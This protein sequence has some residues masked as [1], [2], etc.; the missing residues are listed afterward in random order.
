M[1]TIMTHTVVAVC[2][3]YT[4]GRTTLPK[5]FWVLGI[6]AAVLP[7][8]DVIGLKY[9]H[10]PYGHFLGHRG[11]FHS[12]CFAALFSVVAV[13]LFFRQEPI[14]SRRWVAYV[15]FFFAVG[16][17][18]GLL[19]AMTDGGRGVALLVPFIDERYFLPWTPIEVSPIGIRKF[20]SQRGL[21]VMKS[22]MLWIW[23]PAV[24]LAVLGWMI[25]RIYLKMKK[26]L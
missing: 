2:A 11:F 10:I 15:L 9:L 25:R 3:G 20:V 26:K 12:P 5:R 6:I 21:N 16:A 17:S 22:E 13:S 14:L 1:P 18:H 7:D 4:L 8:A 23:L 19:D 24:T